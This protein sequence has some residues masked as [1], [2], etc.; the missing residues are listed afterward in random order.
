MT[1]VSARY[2]RRRLDHDDLRCLEM[3]EKRQIL[4]LQRQSGKIEVLQLRQSRQVQSPFVS[5]DDPSRVTPRTV[6]VQR[7]QIRQAIQVVQAASR[8]NGQLEMLQ[9]REP[10]DRGQTTIR[11]PGIGDEQ[12]L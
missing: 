11:Y 10:A 7:T 3:L 2:A 5:L 8:K 12:V 9:L 1:Q 4:L 6:R